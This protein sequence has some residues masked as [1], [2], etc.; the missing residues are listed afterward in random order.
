MKKVFLLGG[1]S[2]SGKSTLGRYFD[3]KGVPRLKIVSFLKNVMARDGAVG[4]FAAWNDE[5]TKQRPE[6]VREAFTANFLAVTS[7]KAIDYCALESLYSPDLALYMKQV[8]GADRVIIVYVD[9]DVEVRLQRQMIREN[10]TSMDDAKR[11]LLPR[12]ER[13]KE[14]GVPGI[15]AVADFVVDNSGSLDDLYRIADDIIRKHC[16]ELV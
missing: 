2:E 15:K 5:N 10:L 12:D 1:M 11:L 14:W 6:W 13:K 4:D 3:S 16:P 9:M 7:E 8:L